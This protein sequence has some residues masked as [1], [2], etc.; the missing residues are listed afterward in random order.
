MLISNVLAKR[1]LMS[2]HNV[3]FWEAISES[4]YLGPVAQ[5][6]VSGQNVNCSSKYNI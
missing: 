3:H 1:F 2:V 5:S 4:I 6:I